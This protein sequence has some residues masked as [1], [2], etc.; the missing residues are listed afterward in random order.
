MLHS[1]DKLAAKAKADIAELF[2]LLGDASTLERSHRLWVD[3]FAQTQR[4][5]NAQ[6]QPQESN[7][8]T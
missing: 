5:Q 8:Q 3:K 6:K 7:K 1:F 4:E 2:I